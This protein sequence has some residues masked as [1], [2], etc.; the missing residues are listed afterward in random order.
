MKKISPAKIERAMEVAA[1]LAASTAINGTMTSDKALRHC[2][3]TGLKIVDSME[4]V[5]AA[6]E[7]DPALLE[8]SINDGEIYIKI[9]DAME[10]LRNQ[11]AEREEER[12]DEQ[13][14]EQLTSERAQRTTTKPAGRASR[15]AAG[16][17][18]TK[19]NQGSGN[20]GTPAE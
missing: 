6:V 2:C 16:I 20:T 1:V 9:A 3:I 5:V 19:T 4:R 7:N 15:D 10:T 12:Q 17:Q 14:A 8:M 18:Q 11:K 13:E